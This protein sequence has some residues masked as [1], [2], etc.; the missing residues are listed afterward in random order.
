MAFA[1]CFAVPVL[2]ALSAGGPSLVKDI[3]PNPSPGVSGLTGVG[4]RLLF[5]ASTP[6][7]GTELWKSDGTKKGT[8]LV[9]DIEPS[10]DSEPEELTRVGDVLFFT[11]RTGDAKRELWR[12]KGTAASTRLVKDIW[13][14]EGSRTARCRRT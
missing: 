6:E 10:G 11:A 3:N 4:D 5:A 13:P 2:S 7:T 14:D 9:E 1:A 8:R 12:S